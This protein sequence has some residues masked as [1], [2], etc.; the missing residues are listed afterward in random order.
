[1]ILISFILSIIVAATLSSGIDQGIVINRLKREG[2]LIK[3]INQSDD[4]FK[5]IERND[6]GIVE[7]ASEEITIKIMITA[8]QSKY[9]DSAPN[10][11]QAYI[12]YKHKDAKIYY[13]HIKKIIE[14]NKNE[15]YQVYKCSKTR[16]IGK[17]VYWYV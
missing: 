4:S 11:C 5:V 9:K 12:F 3:E 17:T 14:E 8:V 2:Y 10:T 7:S 6:D 16:I 1:M 15:K 13:N